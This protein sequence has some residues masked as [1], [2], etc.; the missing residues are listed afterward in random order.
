MEKI[1]ECRCIQRG[2]SSEPA[3]DPTDRPGGQE[4]RGVDVRQRGDRDRC[5]PE[6]FGHHAPDAERDEG[7]EARVLNDSGDQLLA[8][9]HR[10]DKYVAADAGSRGANGIGL[11]QVEYNAAGL[12]LVRAG[13]RRLDGDRPSDR[14]GCL[15]SLGGSPGDDAAGE[16][17]AV[18]PQ[19]PLGLV[20]GEPRLFRISEG[21]FN[22]LL[23]PGSGRFRPASA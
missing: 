11:T 15:G 20:G 7:T 4:F 13:Y 5:R 1:D 3:Y 23:R 19:Q 21:A 6:Q 8:L 17:N 22:R 9:E 14:R 18:G 12:G 2:A 10:L 16:W